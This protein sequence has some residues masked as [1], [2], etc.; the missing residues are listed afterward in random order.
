MTA[1]TGGGKNTGINREEI[2]EHAT[3]QPSV[4]WQTWW[5]TNITHIEHSIHYI[6]YPV[7]NF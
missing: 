1:R 3:R 2:T 4:N 5:I 6:Q 7:F